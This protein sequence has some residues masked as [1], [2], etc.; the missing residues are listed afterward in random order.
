MTA[1]RVNR[2]HVFQQRAEPF[3]PL[4]CH[5]RLTVRRT[6]LAVLKA[7]YDQVAQGGRIART[8]LIPPKGRGVYEWL[9]PRLCLE[10]HQ[11]NAGFKRNAEIIQ[12]QRLLAVRASL[13]NNLPVEC[14][15]VPA[16]RR[17]EEIDDKTAG[18]MFKRIGRSSSDEFGRRVDAGFEGKIRKSVDQAA[19]EI[20]LLPKP[21]R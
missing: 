2:F 21:A 13:L 5:R 17:Q 19:L 4:G 20:V 14:M 9:S 7:G 18:H 10:N 8:L 15:D 16:K 6:T 11:G 1:L 3:G 12:K